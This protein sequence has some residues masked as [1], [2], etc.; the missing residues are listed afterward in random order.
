MFNIFLLWFGALLRLFPNRRDLVLE[1]FVLR[2]QLGVLK[3]RR[4]RPSLSI[5]D[6]LFW[7]GISQLYRSIS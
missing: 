1:N 2:Q 7:V 3:R 4:L 5:F 6:K